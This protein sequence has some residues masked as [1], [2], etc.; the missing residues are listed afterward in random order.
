MQGTPKADKKRSLEEDNIFV[1]KKWDLAEVIEK[2]FRMETYGLRTDE[3][4]FSLGYW[5][6]L[7]LKSINQFAQ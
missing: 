5:T 3:T 2:K 4:K 1:T 7:S 6:I